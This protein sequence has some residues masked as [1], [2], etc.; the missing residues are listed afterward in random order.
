MPLVTSQPVSRRIVPVI[1]ALMLIT[2]PASAQTGSITGSIIDDET[3]ETLIGANVSI[4]GT[5]VGTTSD[6]EGRYELRGL[7]PGRYD[8]R[9]SF[10]GYDALVVSGVSVTAEESTEVNVRLYP[11]SIGLDE[12]TVQASAD[13]KS[14]VYG[15]E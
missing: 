12:V 9:F 15:R 10:I 3:G 4:D 8:I 2:L 13:R 5:T 1:L 14:V 7:A 6:F 11:E